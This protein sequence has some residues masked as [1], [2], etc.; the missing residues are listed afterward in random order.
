MGKQDSVKTKGAKQT[1]AQPPL[2]TLFPSKLPLS[3]AV[4]S[5]GPTHNMA[6]APEC[7]TTPLTKQDWDVSFQTFESEIIGRINALLNPIVGQ[8]GRA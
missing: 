3:T 1:A 4:S 7:Q 2:K 5:A 8:V 6:A